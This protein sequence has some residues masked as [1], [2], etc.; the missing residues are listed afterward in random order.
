[1]QVFYFSFGFQWLAFFLVFYEKLNRN[2]KMEN[3]TF[4]LSVQRSALV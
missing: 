4:L 2:D 1:M 3:E